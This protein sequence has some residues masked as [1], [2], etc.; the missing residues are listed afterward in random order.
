MSRV[1]AET[2]TT[3]SCVCFG[4]LK[5]FVVVHGLGLKFSAKKEVEGK[6]RV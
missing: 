4:A 6:K 1:V 5:F 2:T 3:C